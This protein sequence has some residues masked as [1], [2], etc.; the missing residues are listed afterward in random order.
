MKFRFLILALIQ[1]IVVFP[2]NNRD[3]SQ[4]VATVGNQNTTFKNYLDR[5]EDY[6]IGTGLRD[7]MQARFAILNNMINEILLRNYDDN[8]RIYNNPEYIREIGWVKKETILAFLKDQEVYAKITASEDELRQAYIRSKTNVSVRH[9][10]ASTEKEADNLYNLLKIGVSFEELAKQSFTDT[11]LKN[12][13]GYLGFINWGE[14][15]PDFENAAYSLKIGEIS[16]PVKT[17][18]GYSVIKVEDKIQDPFLTE[19][20]F[21]NMKH[22]LERAVKISKKIPS[23]SAYLK[24]IFDQTLVKFNDKALASVLNDLQNMNHD[25]SNYSESNNISQKLYKDCVRFKDKVYSQRDIEK[26]ILEVPKYNRDLLT[27]IERLKSAVIG[28]IMQDVL[29]GIAV[30]KGYDTNSYVLETEN[31]LTDNI[32]LNYKKNEIYDLVPVSDSEI[33]KYYNDNSGFYKSEREMNV[34]EIVVSNDS[35]AHVLINKIENG[36]DFGQLGEKYSLR[37]W[38]AEKKGVMGFSPVSFF[39]DMEDTLWDS[40]IGKVF[41]PVKFDNYFGIFRVLDKKDGVPVDIGLVKKQITYNIQNIKGFPYMEKRLEALAK[42][43]TVKFNSDL[44]KNYNF[45]LAE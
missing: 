25:A 32:F 6:L 27:D 13:G 31:K 40:P 2:Q 37:K 10:Y 22:K 26:K 18:Q 41:G 7:N 15:D 45:N 21:V 43:T 19:N 1:V 14:T 23:E 11:T 44:I 12:N 9:L 17:A 35:L 3:T 4:I 20:D 5:Y 42:K 16:K 29:L 38:S 34:Q 33:V 28:L 39:G 8:S 24:Q 36:E 30:E